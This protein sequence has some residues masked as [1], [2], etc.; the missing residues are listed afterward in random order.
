MIVPAAATAT[1]L[2]D[3]ESALRALRGAILVS[4]QEGR[5][6]DLDA[7]VS[8]VRAVRESAQVLELAAVK[9]VLEALEN[10]LVEHHGLREQLRERAAL[11]LLDMISHAEAESIKIGFREE[12]RNIDL[13]DFI[14]RSFETLQMEMRGSSK[15]EVAK[16]TPPPPLDVEDKFEPDAEMLE[17]FVMEAEDLLSN[18]ET[19]LDV[20]V[21]T[22]ADRNSLWEIRRN[23]HTFKGAA[24]IIG[25]KEPS[26]LAHR[27]E[28]LLEH[29][30]H[31]EIVPKRGVL[32]LIAGSTQCLRAMVAGDRTEGTAARTAGLYSAFEKLFSELTN[33]SRA[34]EAQPKHDAVPAANERTESMTPEADAPAPRPI[35][36]V[37]ISRL[38]ELVGSVRDLAVSRSAVDQQLADFETQLDL[39]A[40]VTRRLRVA[41]ARIE[42]DYEGS[43]LI[44]QMPVSFGNYRDSF[45]KLTPVTTQNDDFDPLE[46]DR[47]TGFH[48]SS[49]E[50]SE[51]IQECFSITTSLEASKAALE[52]VIADQRRLID[53]TQGRLVQIRLIRFG[54][55]MTRLQRA[56]RVACEEEKKKAEIVIEN[57]E[58]ELDTDVL[59]A[60]VEP[61]MHLVRNAVAHGIESP[62]TRRLVGKPESGKVTVSVVNEE[63]HVVLKVSDD[64]RGIAWSALKERAVEAGLIDPASAAGLGPESLSSLLFHPGLTTAE[65]LTM[66]AGR[67]VGM[68]I[69]KE[70]VE[71]RKG[72]ISLETSAH[73]G[74]AFSLRIPLAFA[75]AQVLLVRTGRNLTAVPLKCVKEVVELSHSDLIQEPGGLTAVIGSSRVPVR[76]L[77]DHFPSLDTGRNV[78]E[79]F[80]ALCLETTKGR[81]ALIVDQVVKTEETAIKPLGRPLDTIEVLIGAALLG[82]GEVVAVVDPTYL[83]KSPATALESFASAQAANATTI[84][85]IVDDSPS[86][87]HMTSKVISSAGWEFITAKDGAEALE[88]LKGSRKPDVIL[89]DVEMPRMDGYQLAAAVKADNDVRH[90]PFVFIT[91]R[92]STKHREKAAELGISEYLTKPFIESEL[93]DTVKRLTQNGRGP[94]T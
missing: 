8:A 92:G 67:G 53:E 72:T 89:S 33:P 36:R 66:S 12:D 63:T 91:S 52:A 23:A 19:N 64:G 50:L 55:I 45:G 49:R 79:T 29:L 46:M 5:P 26:A 93:V 13:G 20:L 3:S 86:I 83:L 28:D 32:D 74:T 56:V 44:S 6:V 77:S 85:L 70:S 48:E 30:A 39:L 51:A 9:T 35:V 58:V 7:H 75:F 59:D 65:K 87:R 90:I 31:N 88:L 2:K 11:G 1:F 14:D 18:I 40:K 22:P 10:E 16:K 76:F 81:F 94:V 4:W 57:Q 60:L 62:E 42:N 61:L 37:S 54:S 43:Q 25:L 69:I 68:S 17:V 80:D 41:N 15:P 24:G 82:N 84:V 27:I 34:V 71:S 21:K 73:Q 78:G 47:Y 38:D